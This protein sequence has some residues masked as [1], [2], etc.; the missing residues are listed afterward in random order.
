MYSGAGQERDHNTAE[1]AA[2]VKN[3]GLGYGILQLTPESY[4]KRKSN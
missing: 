3:Q 4:Q 2:K 1:N